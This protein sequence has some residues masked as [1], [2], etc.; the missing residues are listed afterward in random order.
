MLP[1]RRVEER[2]PERRVWQSH[3]LRRCEVSLVVMAGPPRRDRAVRVVVETWRRV[4][5]APTRPER[6]HRA[7][8]AAIIAPRTATPAARRLLSLLPYRDGSRTEITRLLFSLTRV[9]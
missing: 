4:A 9:F 6:D 5:C 8:G 2:R 7:G 3:S 1:G